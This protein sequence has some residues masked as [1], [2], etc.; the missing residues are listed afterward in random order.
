MSIPPTNMAVDKEGALVVANNS[1]VKFGP[2]VVVTR[3]GRAKVVVDKDN[4]SDSERN[5]QNNFSTTSR[6]AALADDPDTNAVME[7]D[8]QNS[9]FVPPQQL[10]TS[11]TDPFNI[12]KHPTLK[13]S[14]TLKP[15]N[16]L[17]KGKQVAKA[18]LSRPRQPN[19][20][21]FVSMHAN[22]RHHIPRTLSH[23]THVPIAN[24]PVTTHCLPS[25]PTFTVTTLDPHNHTTMIFLVKNHTMVGN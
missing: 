17:A 15:H 24:P 20:K 13:T 25:E 16:Y 23:I 7:V 9:T 10:T 3:K 12:R 11:V 1:R 14:T 6:F 5:Q 4:I 21:P 18:Q 19:S 8:V 22:L 2:W